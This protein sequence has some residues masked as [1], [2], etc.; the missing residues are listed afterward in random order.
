MD[1]AALD[2]VAVLARELNEV[3]GSRH[4]AGKA[5]PEFFGA[6][7]VEV[8]D[9]FGVAMDVP[10]QGAAARD[11]HGAED[12]GFVHGQIEAAVPVDAPHIAQRLGERLPQRDAHILGGVVVIHL[13]VAV[14]DEHQ[15]KAPVPRNSSSIWFRKPQPVST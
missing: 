10:V 6:L 11:V 9:F 8:A 1:E 5:Q 12:E 3:D 7:H 2:L 15:I 4:A 14:A 13:H